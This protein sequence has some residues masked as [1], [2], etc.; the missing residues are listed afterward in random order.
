MPARYSWKGY[1]KLSLV[2]CPVQ[3][4]PATST[5]ERVSFHLLNPKT[6]HRI[7]TRTIDPETGD[8]I[9]RSELVR[10][11]EYEKGRYIV[12]EAEELAS[13]E[14]E[15]TQTIDLTRFVNRAM[16]D[17]IYLNSAYYVAPDGKLGDE[18]FRVI[19]DA[20]A[21]TKTAG[22]GRIVLSAREHPVMVEPRDSGMIMYTLRSPE[23]VRA[24]SAYFA[25]IGTAKLDPEMVELAK[26]I[27]AQKKGNFDPEELTGDRYQAALRDLVARKVSGAKPAPRRAAAAPSNVVNLMDA[28]RRSIGADKEERASPSARPGGKKARETAEPAHA[29]RKPRGKARRAS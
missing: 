14:V 26:R 28:L 24:A 13:L 27:L 4:A 5:R 18:T 16:V 3:A 23:E 22:I 19:R 2:S 20:M 17:P 25:E 1:L 8:E 9:R 6:M 10:G 15:S 21:D 12:V 7:E 29:G 11:Y